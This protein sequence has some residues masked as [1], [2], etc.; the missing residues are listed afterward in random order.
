MAR[1]ATHV[2]GLDI[3]TAFIK[4]AEIQ[5]RGEEYHVVSRPAV[6][7]TPEGAVRG[8]VIVD[9]PA[10]AEALHEI[11]S[12]YGARTKKVIASVG[13][14]SSVVVRITEVPRMSGKE[15]DEAIQWELDEQT[16]F[17]V[18]EVIYDYAPI[19]RPDADPEATEME[20]L[21][22]VAQEDLVAAHVEA[23]QGGG[24]QPVAID[25]EPLAIGRAIVDAAGPEFADQ[26]VVSVH[27]GATNSL[28]LIFRHRILSFVRVIP[29]AGENLTQAMAQ[30]LMLDQEQAE[31]V[32]LQ[33]GNLLEGGFVEEPADEF[34]GGGMFEDEDE[35]DDFAS[36]SV[37]ELSSTEESADLGPVDDRATHL[38]ID[39]DLGEIEQPPPAETAPPPADDGPKEPQDPDLVE[40]RDHVAE[41][42][43]EPV[44]DIATEVRR[45]LD[46]YRRQHRNE[47][48]D[49]IVITGGSANLEGLAQLMT[50][51]TGVTA[52]V[53]NPFKYM[54]IDD[55][56]IPEQY[57]RDIGPSSVVAIGLALRD[58]VPDE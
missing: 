57:L 51:E 49:R 35:G 6:I 11:R 39:Q 25:V 56:T 46:F 1:G 58:M 34:G 26:T 3:G 22:A 52:E 15:L 30:S 24:M 31:V 44:L 29:S 8:G 40:A 45:S 23:I 9:A 43:T 17:P 21:M 14:D 36:D 2:L 55:E 53:G 42:L 13:G 28:I 33:L 41:A 27:I 4:A 54:Q 10:V 32:K 16:P 19:E 38:E 50:D 47:P 37:F 48:I 7:P 20:V 12:R 5:L 18:D